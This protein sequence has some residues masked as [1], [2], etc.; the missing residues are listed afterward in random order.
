MAQHPA[1]AK[2]VG[3]GLKKFGLNVAASRLTTGHNKI[4]E[5]LEGRLAGFFEAE[6]AAVHI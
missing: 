2:A 3:D 5:L 4:Y 6:D 1:V